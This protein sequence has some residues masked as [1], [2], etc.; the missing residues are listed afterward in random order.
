MKFQHNHRKA[1]TEIAKK[2]AN[3]EK[4]LRKENER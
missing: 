4:K 2:A 3:E 1:T